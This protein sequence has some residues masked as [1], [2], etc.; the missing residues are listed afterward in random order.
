MR[1][2]GGDDAGAV[3][4][5]TERPNPAMIVA[6]CP[7]VPVPCDHLRSGKRLPR[8]EH[9]DVTTSSQGRSVPPP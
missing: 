9:R 5:C 4:H 2:M 8:K 7:A 1:W 6:A 3:G